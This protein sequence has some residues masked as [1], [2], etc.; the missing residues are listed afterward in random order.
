M[1]AR[2]FAGVVEQLPALSRGNAPPAP[3]DLE[4]E[5]KNL[6]GDHGVDFPLPEVR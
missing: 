2:L 3:L 5:R 4:G 6:P 1:L